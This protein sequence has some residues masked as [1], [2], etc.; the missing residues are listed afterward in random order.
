MH[1]CLQGKGSAPDGMQLILYMDDAFIYEVVA[2]ETR[3]PLA[4]ENLKLQGV[5]ASFPPP[6]LQYAQ[7]CIVPAA[8]QEAVSSWLTSPHLS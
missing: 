1:S 4:S 6:S 3:L 5:L 8:V 2:G 7:R